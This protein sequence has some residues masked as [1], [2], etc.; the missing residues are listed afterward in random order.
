MYSMPRP[1]SVRFC[2]AALSGGF[3]LLPCVPE[4]ERLAIEVTPEI[5]ETIFVR[6]QRTERRFL[7]GADSYEKDRYCFLSHDQCDCVG[8]ARWH[9]DALRRLGTDCCRA[10]LRR[11]GEA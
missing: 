2:S 8:F 10:T 6:V 4:T 1:E 9:G 5:Y 7:K 11:I 3:F